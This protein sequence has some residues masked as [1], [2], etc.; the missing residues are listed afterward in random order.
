M[1][2][3][4]DP[5]LSE[6][7]SEQAP[8]VGH[9]LRSRRVERGV[10]LSNV[11][12]AL[13]IEVTLIEALEANRF[14]A[15]SAP[16]FA[17]GYLK[18]Y[19]EYLGLPQQE[20]MAG[21]FDQ[22]GREDAPMVGPNRPI[23]LRDERQRFMW[24]VLAIVFGVILTAA[25]FWWRSGDDPAPAPLNSI[26]P[27]S[28]LLEFSAGEQALSLPAAPPARAVPGN[29]EKDPEPVAAAA[30]PDS[31]SADTATAVA[32]NV[33]AAPARLTIGLEFNED[34]WAEV[35]DASGTRLFYGLGRP[36]ARSRFSGVPPIAFLFGNI[37]GVTLT[38]DGAPYTVPRESRQG[39]LARFV[40]LE[41]GA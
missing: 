2:E 21:Y 31:T 11:S 27:L 3:P 24:I 16:V 7:A 19:A 6:E 34:C 15:F 17:K 41:A 29:V 10:E 1:S 22:V 5:A 37:A 23:T 9:Q 12:H 38:I 25:F 4:V 26:A 35:T 30:E 14:D 32:D 18:R 40:I 39:N 28:E 20:I 13:R 33:V 36:G 8:S